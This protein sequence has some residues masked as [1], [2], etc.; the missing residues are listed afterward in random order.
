MSDVMRHIREVL[1]DQKDSIDL[2]SAEDS[3]FRDIC[4]DFDTCVDALNF[5]RSSDA[6][7]AAARALEYGELVEGLFEEISR[8]LPVKPKTNPEREGNQ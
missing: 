5:W 6:A 3:L 1:S 8:T 2:L 4:N 7:D